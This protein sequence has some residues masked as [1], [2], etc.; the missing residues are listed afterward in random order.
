[1]KCLKTL[2]V[3]SVLAALA[4]GVPAAL[5]VEVAGSGAPDTPGGPYSTLALAIAYV[6]ANSNPPNTINVTTNT[7]GATGTGNGHAGATVTVPVTI[8]GDGET[9]GTGDG[10]RCVMYC[11]L[12]NG[13]TAG[14]GKAMIYITAGPASVEIRNLTLVPDAQGDTTTRNTGAITALGN[15]GGQLD[16]NLDNVQM[17]ATTAAGAPI[18]PTTDG[19]ATAIRF[20]NYTRG[21]LETIV[22][23]NINLTI[24]NCASSNNRGNGMWIA[25]QAG[26]FTMTAPNLITANGVDGVHFQD[27]QNLPV[28]FT[29]SLQVRNILWSNSKS[30]AGEGL[31]IG[32]TNGATETL[33]VQVVEY[34]DAIS[35]GEEG[36]DIN[37]GQCAITRYCRFG[38]NSVQATAN[39]ENWRIGDA[40]S[41]VATVNDCTMH[42]TTGTDVTP[43]LI[44]DLH[45]GTTNF[46][47]CIFTAGAAAENEQMLINNAG[48]TWNLTN[49]AV[50]TSG[51]N[52]LN[53]TTPILQ[54][55]GTVNQIAVISA[56]PQYVSTTFNPADTT[57][58]QSYLRPSNIAAYATAGFGG[59]PLIG[60][61]TSST[62]VPVELSVF[63]AN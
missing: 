55:A 48:L 10:T 17:L 40:A 41:W 22:G 43:Q 53:A 60:G 27:C 36:M 56:D 46:T 8:N 38:N 15:A 50:V 63:S 11:A 37:E 1:M 24:H 32:T 45:T 2:S 58:N 51:P 16:L 52:A 28:N 47:N 6:N 13:V 4:V 14:V 7:L 62:G 20:Y 23:N 30:S 33:N 34:T 25:H 49:C 18:S 35:N 21:T 26:A 42:N 61:A 44:E 12:N 54:T 39:V 31:F 57:G 19:Y 9:S 59:G 29:G 3:I 5:T